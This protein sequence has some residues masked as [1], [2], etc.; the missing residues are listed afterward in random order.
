MTRRG[1][2]SEA[3]KIRRNKRFA[4]AA[5]RFLV[6]VMA[7]CNP[8]FSPQDF[9]VLRAQVEAVIQPHGML[10]V[11]G[12]EAVTSVHRMAWCH[13]AMLRHL[14]LTGQNAVG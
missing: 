6:G 1:A 7:D 8:T 9:G 14:G 10:D 11:L 12:R 13:S 5:L 4:A 2:R 3:L